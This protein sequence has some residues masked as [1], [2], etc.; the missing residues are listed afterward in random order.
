M[1]EVLSEHGTPTGQMVRVVKNDLTAEPVDAIVN[2][3]NERLA[4]GGG[5][6]GAIARVGGRAIQRESI[7]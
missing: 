7:E 1:R 3:A 2:A 6:A 4:H 5:V